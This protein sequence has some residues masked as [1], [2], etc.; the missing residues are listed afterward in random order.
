MQIHNLDGK[1]KQ[2][3]VYGWRSGTVNGAGV[4]AATDLLSIAGFTTLLSQ[5]GTRY[6]HKIK[7]LS[8][9]AAYLRINGGDVITLGATAPFEAEDLIIKTLGVS[10]GGSDITLTVF[11]Q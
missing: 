10:T 2:S 1:N 4:A 11:L 3:T 7:V 5:F 8:S 6:P 9:G